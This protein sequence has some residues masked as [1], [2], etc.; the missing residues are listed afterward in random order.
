MKGHLNGIQARIK[1]IVPKKTFVYCMGHQMNLI[2]QES[3]TIFLEETD[4]LRVL[5]AILKFVS[6][7]P[8]N[9]YDF[10]KKNNF[11]TLHPLCPTQQVLQKESVD[12]F[13]AN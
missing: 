1:C 11:P 6:N 12:A 2:V 13:L 10:N 4:V 5:N 3:I 8:K 9:S 7:S